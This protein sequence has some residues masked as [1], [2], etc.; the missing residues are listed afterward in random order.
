MHHQQLKHPYTPLL[1]QYADVYRIWYQL[2]DPIIWIRQKEKHYLKQDPYWRG[3]R[4]IVWKYLIHT[5]HECS[6]SAAQLL[7]SPQRRISWLFQWSG[8]KK[9]WFQCQKLTKKAHLFCLPP[10]ALWICIRQ[11]MSETK[12]VAFADFKCFLYLK[13]GQFEHII[14]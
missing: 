13:Q 14:V 10:L 5:E 12:R 3:S 6:F 8:Q 9:N 7:L 4:P 11:L 1:L 2:N